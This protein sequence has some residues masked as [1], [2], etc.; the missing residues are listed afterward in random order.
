MQACMIL[1][2]YSTQSCVIVINRRRGL[3]RLYKREAQGRVAPE[4]RAL[5]KPIQTDDAGY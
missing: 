1:Y 5:I 2:I 4:G 3:Y